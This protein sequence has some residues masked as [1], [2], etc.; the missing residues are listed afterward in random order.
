MFN[1]NLHKVRQAKE[2]VWVSLWAAWHAVL[3][4]NFAAAAAL[5]KPVRSAADHKTM[6]I[7]SN[8]SIAHIYSYTYNVLITTIHPTFL[9]PL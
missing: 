5:K 3:L 6:P 7:H 8:T 2:D 4:K 1:N 9:P